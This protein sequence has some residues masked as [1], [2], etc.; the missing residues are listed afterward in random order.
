MELEERQN[1]ATTERDK[2]IKQAQ[3]EFD[4]KLQVMYLSF[5]K[6]FI[7]VLH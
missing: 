4:D 5:E 1:S 3:E 2:A 6:L 7:Y